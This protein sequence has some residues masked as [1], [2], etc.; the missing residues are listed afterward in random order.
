[1]IFEGLIASRISLVL[2]K[3]NQDANMDESKPNFSIF[4]FFLLV[5]VW[6]SNYTLTRN[7]LPDNDKPDIIISPKKKTDVYVNY[8]IACINAIYFIVKEIG[9]GIIGSLIVALVQNMQ[10]P[11]KNGGPHDMCNLGHSPA[12]CRWI[13]ITRSAGSVTLI[14]HIFN[15]K[16]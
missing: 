11:T 9:F 3:P 16:L 12:A 1:M 15:P 14:L 13:H 5:T 8:L 6:N 7:K 10:R 4:F 2:R